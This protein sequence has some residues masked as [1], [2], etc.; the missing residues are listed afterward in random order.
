MAKK[1]EYYAVPPKEGNAAICDNM[2]GT[3]GL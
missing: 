2:D 3:G 1:M